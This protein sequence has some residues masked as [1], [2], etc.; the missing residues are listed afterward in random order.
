MDTAM[1]LGNLGSE[2]CTIY[3]DRRSTVRCDRG[4]TYSAITAETHIH[5]VGELWFQCFFDQFIAV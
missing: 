1:S 3:C 2:R 4:G 5:S